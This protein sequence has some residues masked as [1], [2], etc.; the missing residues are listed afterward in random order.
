MPI[1][2]FRF[3]V[4]NVEKAIDFAYYWA[5]TVFVL[6]ALVL[7]FAMSDPAI[8]YYQRRRHTRS[9]SPTFHS[10]NSV[11]DIITFIFLPPLV[12]TVIL[13]IYIYLFR[14]FHP[15]FDFVIF[16][17]FKEQAARRVWQG[18]NRYHHW[19]APRDFPRF[20]CMIKHSLGCEIRFMAIIPTRF[21]F[22]CKSTISCSDG[23]LTI[24]PLRPGPTSPYYPTYTG[25]AR[26]CS[27]S[28]V[29]YCLPA[30]HEHNTCYH[31]RDRCLF[32]IASTGRTTR[33]HSVVTE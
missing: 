33:N 6:S 9:G 3:V 23:M 32:H 8:R 28:L 24:D 22:W 25:G 29:S 18:R 30:H 15:E 11:G 5:P 16:I 17:R 1:F 7:Y 13:M 31:P 4:E 21:D 19:T 14:H 27:I 12:G 10:S 20:E 26:P 2:L